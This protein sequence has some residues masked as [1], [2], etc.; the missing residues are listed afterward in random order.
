MWRTKRIRDI[1]S[2]LISIIML[3]LIFFHLVHFF[4]FISSLCG[5]R[6]PF[7]IRKREPSVLMLFTLTDTSR[8][9]H[10]DEFDVLDDFML[11]VGTVG[12][13][14]NEKLRYVEIRRNIEISYVEALRFALSRA[15]RRSGVKTAWPAR[16]RGVTGAPQGSRCVSARASPPSHPDRPEEPPRRSVARA[17]GRGPPEQPLRP[18]CAPPSYRLVTTSGGTALRT[19]SKLHFSRRDLR[20]SSYQIGSAS[21]LRFS[22]CNQTIRTQQISQSHILAHQ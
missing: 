17:P 2:Q 18:V 15:P 6:R 7:Q 4:C 1:G 5:A 13:V 21:D 20:F 8:S 22:R 9:T 16:S 19:A 11:M 12:T 10:Y 3:N 14:E